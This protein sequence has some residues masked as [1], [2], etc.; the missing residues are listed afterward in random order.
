M[1]TDHLAGRS[2]VLEALKQE[3]V[4]PAPM[5]DET[6]C[7]QPLRFDSAEQ[8]YGA[9]RQ[10]GNGDEIL[11]RDSPTKRY[12]IGV[13]YPVGTIIEHGLDQAGRGAVGSGSLAKA[14]DGAL[15]ESIA[16]VLTA[17]LE[18]ELAQRGDEL[19]EDS[20]KDEFDIS[21]ANTYRPSSMGISFLAEFQEQSTLIVEASGGH[22]RPLLVTVEGKEKKWWARSPV[23]IR[24]EFGANALCASGNCLRSFPVDPTTPTQEGLCLNIQVFSRPYGCNR[25]VR[26][27]TVCLVNRT[28]NDVQSDEAS[29]F[30]AHFRV[31]VMAA[32]NC[33]WILPYP[34]QNLQ[35]PDAEEQSLALLYRNEETFAV[36]HGCAANWDRVV[37]NRRATWVAAESLPTFEVPSITPEILRDDGSFLKVSMASLAGLV[38]DDD[39]FGSLAGVIELYDRWISSRKNEVALLEPGFRDA[40]IRHLGECARCLQRM[41]DGLECLRS[42]PIARRAFQWANHAMLLQQLH[43]RRDA[44]PAIYDDVAKRLDFPD[45]FPDPDLRHP[46]GG[47]GFW[48]PFQIAFLLM[49][50]RSTGEAK[51]QDRRTVELIWFPTGGGKTEAYLGLAA[52]SL[53]LRRLRNRDDHG[54]DVL[55]RYTLRLLTAQQFQR[56][57]ALICAMES[58]RKTEEAKL[59]VTP[60]SIGIW[61]GSDTTP[62]RSSDAVTRLREL[63]AGSKG[64]RNPFI[65]TRCPWCGAQ[66]G[67][68]DYG[69]RRKMSKFAP[70]VIGYDEE[71]G[72]VVYHCPDDRCE[73]HEFLPIYV[74]DEDIYKNRPSIIIGTVDKFAM[75]AWRPD[76]RALFGID[77]DGTRLASPPNLI[78]QDELHLISG[79]L[80]SMVGL[81]E[82]I[83]EELG[84]DRRGQVLVPPKIVTSTATI[85]RYAEQILG[86]FGRD[87]AALFPPP[88]L[89]VGDSFFAR[90][91]RRP[92]G[93]LQPGRLY[94]GVHAPS[95]GSM[96]TVQV[97]T[98]SALL[99]STSGFQSGED[100]DVTVQIWG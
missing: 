59:G 69:S 34:Q 64:A 5:G 78:I 12:G 85:R 11:K 82:P 22:Y 97:R 39:G 56:A 29:L 26:L 57:C 58:I 25:R 65:L 52:F 79:P 77:S 83:I 68:I 48:R 67:P 40:A 37:K 80:G 27:I 28:P 32:G 33:A 2:K 99:Q 38:P 30:Q 43:A 60:F 94:V 76:A 92:D 84:T 45:E 93:S 41:A 73:F 89:E 55:M 35:T 44:R 8:A 86:L 62:N 31:Q 54:V 70:R 15:G 66:M 13:L 95:L 74:I 16:P 75:L 96:Q 1:V 10:K 81:Y 21:G 4:G 49:S 47:R 100:C 90:Y 91:A 63:R 51:A 61:V 98:F 53:F 46:Q 18:A 19:A 88:G 71:A 7:T 3:L 20:E 36:G 72:T 42:D 23:T 50:L 24:A 17:H 9:H 87:D 14:E 6:D